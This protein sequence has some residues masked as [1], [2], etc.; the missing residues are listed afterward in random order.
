MGGERGGLRFC[1]SV[2][3]Q[4]LLAYCVRFSVADFG[5]EVFEEGG[6]LGF[7]PSN[8]PS[9]SRT[10]RSRHFGYPVHRC[11]CSM[12]FDISLKSWFRLIGETKARRFKLSSRTLSFYGKP[13]G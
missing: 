12:E 13:R 5:L 10:P 4:Q 8:V 1:A 9:R 3:Y 7:Y 6:L 11:A 2:G